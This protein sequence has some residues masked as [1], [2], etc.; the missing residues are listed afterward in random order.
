MNDIVSAVGVWFYSRSTDRHLY[1]IRNDSKHPDCW[2]LAGGKQELGE[3]LLQTLTREC[4][5][6][7]GMMPDYIKLVPLDQFTSADKKFCYH[8]FFCVVSNEF[9]PILNSEHSGYAWI[10]SGTWPRPLH[11]GLWSTVNFAT[12]KEK[13]EIIKSAVQMSQ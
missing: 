11:S 6:E 3:T 8:T 1:L 4:Q 2:S 13:V 5:E 9:Q 10:N 12:I 7:L